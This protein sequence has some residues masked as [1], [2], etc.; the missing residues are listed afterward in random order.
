[1]LRLL[2]GGIVLASALEESPKVAEYDE[3]VQAAERAQ[4]ALLFAQPECKEETTYCTTCLASLMDI[5]DAQADCCESL[6]GNPDEGMRPDAYEMCK[7]SIPTFKEKES[8]RCE[9]KMPLN[10][11]DSKVEKYSKCIK[12][13]SDAEAAIYTAHP[14]CATSR[15]TYCKDCS[16]ALKGVASMTAGCCTFLE[17]ELEPGMDPDAHENCVKMAQKHSCSEDETDK[18]EDPVEAIAD[19]TQCHDVT[20]GETQTSYK[21]C[22]RN[23]VW[24]KDVGIKQRPEFYAKYAFLKPDSSLKDFQ[25]ALYAMKGNSAGESWDCPLPCANNA[26]MSAFTKSVETGVADMEE[27]ISDAKANMAET[28]I[29]KYSA[30]NGMKKSKG[31][32]F[33]IMVACGVCCCLPLFGLCCSAFL[34]YE[35]VSWIFGGSDDKPQKRKKRN[36][37]LKKEE[38]A[39]QPAMALPGVQLQPIVQTTRSPAVYT[40]VP[41][42]VVPMPMVQPIVQQNLYAY[43]A[44]SQVAMPLPTAVAQPQYSIIQNQ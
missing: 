7:K 22:Y 14:D 39:S 23:L 8:R 25:E 16:E 40:T 38:A 24:A 33:W 20:S 30:T 32:F 31:I 42:H 2:A 41:T 9:G 13:S 21:E 1:M 27:Q 12:D 19:A 43:P 6:K 37:V 4:E 29:P 26:A 34:C 28:S 11:S 18:I 3:C 5:L 36:I 44:V 10:A 35:S 17:G 15:K